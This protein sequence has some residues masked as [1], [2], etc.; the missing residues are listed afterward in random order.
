MK[1]FKSSTICKLGKTD[2]L[3]NE[4][5]FNRKGVNYNVVYST[6]LNKWYLNSTNKQ[7]KFITIG[8][9]N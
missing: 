8:S 5:K 2:V 9:I 6:E 3:S 4:I 7:G 1:N